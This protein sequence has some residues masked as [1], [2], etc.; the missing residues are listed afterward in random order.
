[1]N[2]LQS[3]MNSSQ[4]KQSELLTFTSKLTEKNTQLQSDNACLTEKLEQTQN[5]LDKANSLMDESTIS[6]KHEVK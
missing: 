2:E 5:D 6:I 3:E 1:M 4:L